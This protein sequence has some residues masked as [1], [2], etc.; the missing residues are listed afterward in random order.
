MRRQTIDADEPP[1]GV[2]PQTAANQVPRV[3][4]GDKAAASAQF[5]I[6]KPMQRRS[7]AGDDLDPARETHAGRQDGPGQAQTDRLQLGGGEGPAVFV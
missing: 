4:Y 6:G 3:G 7:Q 2:E 5:K 1:L